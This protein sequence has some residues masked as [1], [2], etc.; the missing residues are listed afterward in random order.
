MFARLLMLAPL[1]VVAAVSAQAHEDG[2]QEPLQTL[3]VNAS[4]DVARAPDLAIVTA[5][6]QTDA[7][8]AQAAMADNAR[9]MAAV[10]ATL[11]QRGVAD[12]DMQTSGLSLNA[13]YDYR[14]GDVPPKLTGYQATNTLTLKLRKLDSAGAMLDALVA[15]GVNQINGPNFDLSDPEAALDEARQK[16][17]RMARARAEL[18]A[19]AA[20]L[21]VKRILA[22]SEGGAPGP[23][24]VF[25]KAARMAAAPAEVATDLA[26]GEVSRTAT[27]SITF[28]LE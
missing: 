7:P 11:K 9:R 28:E 6:V 10:M 3:V 25:L 18:Y 12:K 14:Q 16:A 4:A 19:T 2:T 13:R 21:K 1:A 20:G 26:P 5:G 24:P 23:Q 15:A 8:T 17:V 27:V 22:I